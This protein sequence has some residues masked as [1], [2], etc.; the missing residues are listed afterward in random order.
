MFM[1]DQI[2]G[3]ERTNINCGSQLISSNPLGLLKQFEVT[4]KPPKILFRKN[5]LNPQ[6][7]LLKA[8]LIQE[9]VLFLQWLNLP[10]IRLHKHLF[11]YN[12]SKLGRFIEME[13]SCLF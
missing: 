3:F 4:T 6:L 13:C 8:T 12:I 11:Y 2:C 9:G 5:Q 1:S 7:Q 10:S